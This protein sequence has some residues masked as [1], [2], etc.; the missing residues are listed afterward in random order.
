MTASIFA[1]IKINISLHV[2]PLRRDGYHPVDTLCVFPT[3]GDV[4]SYDPEA[5]TGIDFTG[6]FG[7]QLAE[8]SLRGNLV[9]KAFGLLGLA[10]QGRFL[11]SKEVPIAS[12]VGAGTADGAAAMLLVNALLELGLSADELIFASRGLGADGP[13]CMAG[14]IA[15]GGLWRAEGAGEIISQVG[16]VE[17]SAIVVAN[18]GFGISTAAVF[19]AYDANPRPLT[20]SAALRGAPLVETLERTR[21]DL[22]PPALALSPEISSLKDRLR[23]QRGA[24][25]VRMS[26]SGATCYALHAG[27]ASAYNAAHALRSRGIWAEAGTLLPGSMS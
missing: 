6:P 25:A 22:E 16:V 2:G 4:L 17:P 18:P 1:P 7:A 23:G 19:K 9:W 15:G 20:S 27:P 13:V 12:G 10:P 14:Q 8:E 11:L 3:I 24:R 5:E 26:G 21:N